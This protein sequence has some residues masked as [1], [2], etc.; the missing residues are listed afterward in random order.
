MP[1]RVRIRKFLNKP[2]YCAGAYVFAEVEDSTKHKR[3]KHDWPTFTS[4]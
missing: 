3:G 4:I 1:Y 2:G